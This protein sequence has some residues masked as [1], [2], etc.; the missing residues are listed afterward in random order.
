MDY[1]ALRHFADTWGLVFLFVIFVGV[2]A[3]VFRPGSKKKYERDAQIPL[4]DNDEDP[5]N[6]QARD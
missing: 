1:D 4:K 3:F 5:K 6:G 2:I